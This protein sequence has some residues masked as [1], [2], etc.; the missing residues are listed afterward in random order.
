MATTHL[1]LSAL[2]E[3]SK[4]VPRGASSFDVRMAGLTRPAYSRFARS[5]GLKSARSGASS[6][7]SASGGLSARV[8]ARSRRSDALELEELQ[9]LFSSRSSV[10]IE[11][12]VPVAVFKRYEWS[13]ENRE[14]AA[15]AREERSARDDERDEIARQLYDETQDRRNKVRGRNDRA[16]QEL[17][18]RN[19]LR[20][21][22]IRQQRQDIADEIEEQRQQRDE[23]VRNAIADASG[24]YNDYNARLAAQEEAER[25]QMM[26]QIQAQ[27]H[28]HRQAL[29]SARRRNL[30]ANRETA[31]T[32]RETT[33]ARL[34]AALA[35]RDRRK[36]R[37]AEEQR[38]RK[39][40][41]REKLAFNKEA[42]LTSARESKA[43]TL[44]S[45]ERA[46]RAR[47]DLTARRKTDYALY[48]RL[49]EDRLDRMMESADELMAKSQ[50]KRDAIF[51]SRFIS[52]EAAERFENSSFRKLHYMDDKA[53]A[54]IDEEN[55]ELVE[56]IAK[57][58]MRVDSEIDDDAA[59]EARKRFAANSRAQKLATS[60]RF[61]RENAQLR[62][63]LLQAHALTDNVLNEEAA[64]VRRKEMRAESK[65]RRAAE[66]AE[67]KEKN[68][69]MKQRLK[70]VSSA[71]FMNPFTWFDT[72]DTDGADDAGGADAAQDEEEQSENAQGL[73]D[74]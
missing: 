2:Q 24:G 48:R 1:A 61:R 23:K 22:F 43:R 41:V 52:R 34:S 42:Q 56:R 18:A 65:A 73:A 19:L 74:I 66:A 67:L 50:D 60:A 27:R 32:V 71:W 44:A 46:T 3:A 7:R 31:V 64:A 33:T 28:E 51:S 13:E 36:A 11:S 53:D 69:E 40:R 4:E 8:S 21:R 70:E 54:Q 38:A 6:A 57:V 5:S 12:D 62:S 49:S 59:G 47:G 9:G 25:E 15:R 17:E 30:M 20:G 68:R 16:K 63:R 29:H 39:A 35:E 58:A 26:Q 10:H 45:R 55:V 14:A 72:D 37:E